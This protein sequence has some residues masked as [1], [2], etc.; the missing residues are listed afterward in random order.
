MYIVI[1][2]PHF[3]DGEAEQITAMFQS[4][5]QRL[6]LRKPEGSEDECRRLLRDIPSCYYDRIVIHDFHSLALEF[7]LG[8]IHLNGRHPQVEVSGWSGDVSVSCHSISELERR[9]REGFAYLSLSPIFD[10]IS[11]K[12]Y[13]AAFSSEELREAKAKGIIDSRVMALGGLCHDNIDEAMAFGFGGVMVLGEAWKERCLPVVL[14][15]AGSDPSAGAGIQQD[16]K[17]MTNCGCYAATVITAVTSQNTLG[18]QGVMPVPADVVESQLRSVFSDMSVAAVKIG[19][20][21]NADVARAIVDV[22]REEKRRSVL[23]VVLDPVMISTSGT[24]LMDEACVDI[25][26]SQLF[27]LCTL[28]TPNIPE[29]EYLSAIPLCDISSL[30]LLRKGGHADGS[31]MTDVLYIKKECCEQAFTSPRISTRNLHGTGCTLSSAIASQLAKRHSLVPAIS[32]A[33]DY[34]NK[35]IMGGR[36][37]CLGKGNGPLFVSPIEAVALQS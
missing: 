24:R 7:S 12:G 11:K 32:F 17:T 2:L 35:A 18:V 13:N 20:I 21:P 1:T 6:H 29:Y 14:T 33:K 8:G 23:P 30:P 31:D 22:L 15:I 28:I 10:S 16:M 26:I 25:I 9:R 19:M 34:M 5:L 36:D 4:G 37:L 3:F 27:P